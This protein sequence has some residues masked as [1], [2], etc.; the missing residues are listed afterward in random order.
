MENKTNLTSEDIFF[1]N[2][3]KI[4]EVCEDKYYQFTGSNFRKPTDFKRFENP[5]HNLQNCENCKK[6]HIKILESFEGKLKKFPDCCKNHSKLVTESWFNKNDYEEMPKIAADKF[7]YSWH[8]ILEH[9]DDEDWKDTILDYLYYIVYTFGVFP[10]NYGEPLFLSTYFNNLKAILKSLDNKRY[11]KKKEIIIE[12]CNSFYLKKNKSNTTDFNIL[13]TIYDKWYKTFPF[14]I[15]IFS[16]LKEKYSRNLPLLEKTHYN[17]YL[18]LN[19]ATPKTKQNLIRLLEDLTNNII[20]EINALSLYEQGKLND[21]EGYRLEIILEKRKLKIKEGYKNDSKNNDSRY[22]NILKAWLKDETEFLK[23][24]SLS[25][26]SLNANQNNLLLDVLFACNKLQENKLFSKCDEN[27][28]TKQI[29]DILELRY[30]T[31]DQSQAGTSSTGKKA[32]SIDGII[33]DNNIQYFIEALNLKS[34]NKEYIISHV[35]KL[36]KNY[37]PKGLKNKFLIVYANVDSENL[38]SFYNRYYSYIDQELEFKYPKVD[39]LKIEN[40]YAEQR[41]IKTQHLRESTY[42]NIYHILLKM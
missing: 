38:E 41:I 17:K 22:R 26:S 24:L 15:S 31:K 28:R 40:N 16:H 9:I 27:E 39:I 29:L 42:I 19:I 2:K 6:N 4:V 13:L 11:N 34:I 30:I 36:E 32:G 3:V 1:V 23:D 8:F 5:R 7:F 25:L 21:I 33:I 10:S 12:F 37:D 18:N 14:G 35:N 20:T